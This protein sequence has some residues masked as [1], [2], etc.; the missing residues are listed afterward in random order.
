MFTINQKRF[1][2]LKKK[3]TTFFTNG[4]NRPGVNRPVRKMVLE[5]IVPGGT[6][7]GANCPVTFLIRHKMSSE[8][9]LLKKSI[10]NETKTWV[11]NISKSLYILYFSDF[12]SH[13][14]LITLQIKHA[15][16]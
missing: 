13:F 4:V 14:D 1:S 5:R 8:S 15:I 2:F 16:R 9:H 7:F 3:F 11:I 10:C 6:G 12:K